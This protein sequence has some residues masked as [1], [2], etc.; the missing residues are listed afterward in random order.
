MR[1]LL[2]PSLALGVFL[3]AS[4][5]A[6][7][8]ERLMVGDFS[9]GDLSGWEAK[10]FSGATEYQFEQRDGKSVLVA[11]SSA[12]AS[13]IGRKIKI[14]LTKTPYVNWSWKVT[15]GLPELDE[16]SKG[17]D[18]YAARLYIVKSGGALIWNTKAVNYVWSGSQSRETHW[19][20]AYSPGNS[21]MLAVRGAGDS[22]GEWKQE[23]RNVR[24]DFK[25]IY[26]KDIKQIEVV[27][28]MTDTDNSGLSATA[29]YGDIYFTSE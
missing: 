28:I 22:V 23:K 8:A 4:M 27:A 9:G 21:T 10:S 7:A 2:T 13:G 20:N 25:R 19:P 29:E 18:D 17:G 6:V 5:A 24:E 16:T 15:N 3:L 26:G 1:K 14:D 12:A 11:S